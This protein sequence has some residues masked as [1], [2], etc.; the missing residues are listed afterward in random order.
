MNETYTQ[1]AH[2]RTYVKPRH[3]RVIRPGS[4][5]ITV[6]Q[7]TSARTVLGPD[8]GPHSLLPGDSYQ[9][10]S[11]HRTVN[12][13]PRR[14]RD[15]GTTDERGHLLTP[16]H[17]LRSQPLTRSL[18]SPAH[19]PPR[20]LPH[21][22]KNQGISET[23]GRHAALL[24][25]TGKYAQRPPRPAPAGP[26][27]P[28]PSAHPSPRIMSMNP[29]RTGCGGRAPPRRK[30]S[31]LSRSP[32]PSRNLRFSAFNRRI[33]ASSSLVVPSRCPASISACTTH[34]RR[35]SAPTPSW[36][37]TTAIALDVDG[38]SP[39]GP[40]H[41]PHST[42]THHRIN[43]PGHEPILPAQ[44]QNG[45]ATN[46]GRFRSSQKNSSTPAPSHPRPNAVTPSTHGPTTTT[47]I[48]PTP[49]AATSPRPHASTPTSTTS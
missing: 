1:P 21:R 7:V 27:R 46:P 44:P 10:Q 12:R 36:R 2:E 32:R 4:S 28:T 37:A 19:R 14:I 43:L 6:H 34:R 33:S 9:P 42:L 30:T 39:R 48:D 16:V 22:V 8:S 26:D 17:A 3:P 23:P 15:R 18:I 38:Y 25:W 5:E 31:P 40:R 29:T 35:L 49:P 45:A 24:T 11:T 47:T 20:G 13:A 41:K